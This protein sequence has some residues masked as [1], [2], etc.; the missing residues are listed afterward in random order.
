[1]S[2]FFHIKFFTLGYFVFQFLSIL[3]DIFP[4]FTSIYIP[5]RVKTFAIFWSREEWFGSLG[6]EHKPTP[7]CGMLGS[8]S[9]VTCWICLAPNFK[10]DSFRPTWFCLIVKV[11]ATQAKFLKHPGYS[12]M[13]NCTFSLH[14]TNVF[15]S[16]CA[17]ITRWKLVKHSFLN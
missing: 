15:C 4:L 14:R 8:T 13:I 16:F 5:R 6:C 7:D 17:V 1:M 12:F 10:I 2:T 9:S 11:L 3:S